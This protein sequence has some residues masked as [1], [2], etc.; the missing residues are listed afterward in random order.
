MVWLKRLVVLIVSLPLGFFGG[1]LL[2]NRYSHVSEDHILLS[3]GVVFLV[4]FGILSGLWDTGSEITRRVY[5][6]LLGGSA[7]IFAIHEL[8]LWPLR[9]CFIGSC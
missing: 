4:V 8:I 1:M 9:V 6:T 2:S 3:M 7:M 5:W